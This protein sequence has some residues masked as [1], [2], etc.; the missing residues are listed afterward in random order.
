MENTDIHPEQIVKTINE[1]F[2]ALRQIDYGELT[3]EE[4]AELK[5]EFEELQEMVLTLKKKVNYG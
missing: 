5:K 2:A 1:N 3:N 4:K